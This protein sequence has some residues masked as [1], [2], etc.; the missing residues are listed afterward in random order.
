M[1]RANSKERRMRNRIKIGNRWVGDGEPTFIIGEVGQN[2]N[3]D[4][5]VAKK[6]IDVA[7]VAGVD[8]VKFC[9]RNL[10]YELTREA[11]DAPY[12]NPNSF[13]PTYGKHRE[14]LEFSPEQHKELQ[15]HCRRRKVVYFSSVCDPRSADE[16]E[17]LKVPV[18]KIASRDLTNLPLLDHVARKGRPIILSTGM[19]TLAE[20]DDAVN[21]ILKRHD[22]LILLQCVSQYP[23]EPQNLNIRAMFT[24]RE[25][26]GCL[27]GYSCHNVGILAP[28][29]A[30]A[31]GACIV[32][33]H[34][35]LSRAMKG[36]DH[37]G[38][39]EPDGLHR[40]VRYIR[41]IPVM[42]GDGK[43]DILPA[44]LPSRKKLAR[45]VV[46]IRPIKK[47]EKITIRMLGL[48]SPGTGLTARHMFDLVGKR[49]ARD[50]A[51][52]ELVALPDFE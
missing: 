20:I 23:A 42:L 18:Y 45:S 31:V 51:Q 35:T 21:A 4:V 22:R 10:K 6:L 27:T 24:L 28:T 19:S 41:Y 33:K 11:Y 8:A 16:M 36:T 17:A 43:K 48:K 52:D 25:R 49:A 39:L 37:A 32:E 26:Y 12:E 44:E 1:R 50:L 30:A 47:G 5:G 15:S 9:K 2:H 14:A 3:G 7:A 34:I 38:S 29:I 13:G 46:P 40:V